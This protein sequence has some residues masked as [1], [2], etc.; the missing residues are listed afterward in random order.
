MGTLTLHR[1]LFREEDVWEGDH[2]RDDTETTE[3]EVSAREAADLLKRE[4]LTFTAT[5]GSWAASPDGSRELFYVPIG[6]ADGC[7]REEITGHL[8]GFPERVEIAIAEA[9]G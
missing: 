6:R 5:G 1:T 7:W 2:P 4:G 8:S 3:Y 9:V